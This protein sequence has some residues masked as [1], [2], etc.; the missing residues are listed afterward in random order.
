MYGLSDNYFINP[1][2]HP[3]LH[4]LDL[5]SNYPEI[6]LEAINLPS[7]E[8]WTMDMKYGVTVGA[9][10]SLLMCSGCR[11][12]VLNLDGLHSPLVL[13]LLRPPNH[14]RILLCNLQSF[15]DHC[16]DWMQCSR[17]FYIAWRQSISI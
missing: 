1:V 4:S 11:L 9:I 15:N 7:L 16:I 12:K 6:V 13:F 5:S 10:L 17:F 3:Q 2:L 8:E 14:V